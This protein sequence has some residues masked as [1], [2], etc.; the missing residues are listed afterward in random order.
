MRFF[1]RL[2]FYFWCIITYLLSINLARCYFFDY[3][4]PLFC[5]KINIA[6]IA[7]FFLSVYFILAER[8]LDYI[9]SLTI[10]NNLENARFPI[11]IYFSPMISYYFL[12]HEFYFLFL[13]FVLTYIFMS[14]RF[15][16]LLRNMKSKYDEQ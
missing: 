16:K 13:L 5:F 9:A 3:E 11:A 8:I 15:C 6:I 12:Y 2:G 7:S 10:I 14:I 4:G 1:S